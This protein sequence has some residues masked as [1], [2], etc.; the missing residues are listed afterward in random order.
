MP[1]KPPEEKS[2]L[3]R[4]LP[5]VD[6]LPRYDWAGSLRYDVLAALT[7]WALLVPEAMAYA[8]IA[9]V[10]PEVGLVTAPLALIGYAIFGSSR[11]LFV[12]PSS[13]VAILSA[14]VVT[15]LA[16]GDGDL[17]LILT[18]WLAIFTGV[19]FVALSLARMGWIANFMASSVLSGFMVGLAIVIAVGQLDKIFGIDAEGDNVLQDLGSIL[20]QFS[21][22][23]W[24]TIAIGAAALAALFLIAA[25]LPKL[26]GALVVMLV[27][28][29][30]SALLGWE[31][32]GIHVV[33][34][35]PAELPNLSLPEWP[36]WDLISDV[37]VGALAV[38]VVAFAE[39]YAAAKSYAARFGYEVDA[40]QEMIGLGVANLGAGLSGG[41]VVDGSLSKTAAGVE[42]GQKTQMTGIVTAVFVLITIVA[43]TWLFE[44]LP[45][46][47]LGAIVIHAV[48]KLIDFSGFVT[49][50]QT[51]RIDFGLAV[52]AFL[53]VILI[54]I[55]V[56]IVIGII[57]SLLALIYRASFPEGTE[58]GR[59]E[60]E[61]GNY[62]F[63]GLSANPDAETL[64]E[65]VFYRQSGSLIFSNAAAF[66][67]QARELLWARTDPPAS[68]LVVD[69][70]QMAD[71]DVTG[72]EEI[73]SLHEELQAADVELWLARLHGDAL[74]TAEK[75]GVI[76]AIG[77]DHVVPTIRSAGQTLRN[78]RS[79]TDEAFEGSDEEA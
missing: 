70:E 73:V 41:F 64:P 12:G 14:S 52:A 29:A 4:Y 2:V 33:G 63:V 25:S 49:L 69:C 57:L 40:N 13:T 37:M 18:V 62:E 71:M 54:D 51:R 61:E 56:G 60:D 32:S 39:S 7:V 58:L 55:L 59:I 9:G 31:E 35:I 72:A 76:A 53:G 38:I 75:A 5:I 65:I 10:P 44:P 3:Q 47:V 36:G 1:L 15:P 17:Y 74:V 8:G 11:H 42:A 78:Q 16:G 45:E 68:V 66:S 48:W 30:A 6:W 22:W 28:I 77:E 26:P 20:E 23:S 24:P 50:W 27:A 46:A 67:Q 43:L 79:D 34:E 21:E 19:F